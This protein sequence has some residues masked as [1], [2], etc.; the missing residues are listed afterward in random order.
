[1]NSTSTQSPYADLPGDQVAALRQAVRQNMAN[2]YSLPEINQAFQ[3]K[4]GYS[5]QQIMEPNPTDFWRSVAQ[6]VTLGHY[7]E[8]KGLAAKL[9]G[10]D[11]TQARDAVRNQDA[12]FAQAHPILNMA[13]QAVAG[14]I[15]G[16]LA[17]PLAGI[18]A[19][20]TGMNVL[21]G[22]LLGAGEGAL[23]GEGY[24]NAP[25]AGGVARDA[26]V[27][28]G[29]GGVLGAGTSA[30]ASKLA[31]AGNPLDNATPVAKEAAAQLPDNISPSLDNLTRQETLAPG[32]TV[33]ADMSPQ[34]TKFVRAVGA[35]RETAMRAVDETQRRVVALKNA[36]NEIGK[37]YDL[38]DGRVDQADDV[39]KKALDQIGRRDLIKGGQVDFGQLQDLRSNLL[40]QARTLG[41]RDPDAAN[42]KRGAA[43]L[44]TNWLQQPGRAPW[45]RNVDADYAFMQNRLSAAKNTMKAV[46]NSLGDYAKA[47]AAGLEPTSMGG[48][49]ITAKPQGVGTMI[50]SAVNPFKGSRAKR[51]AAI[52]KLLGTPGRT[53]EDLLGLSLVHDAL[54]GPQSSPLAGSVS[55]GVVSGGVAGVA[56]SP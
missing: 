7:D 46:Q 56:S 8:L 30:V 31:G 32:T 35:D 5:V 50:M 28:A 16:T 53:Q 26:A 3:Q 17:S 21:R 15:P 55:N 45:I 49:I 43:D 23:A 38:L 19:G 1:M 4:Y 9:S 18:E 14:G 51:A 39:L 20:A 10:G 37:T 6:G 41:N 29:I 34:M 44:I 52:W 27:N 48:S 11:Y 40:K 12:Q 22:G 13:T 24:S 33:L 47:R 2:G 42:T 54:L 25:T 36:A